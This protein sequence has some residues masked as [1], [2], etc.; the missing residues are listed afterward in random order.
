MK[1][2]WILISVILIITALPYIIWRNHVK[3]SPGIFLTEWYKTI[4][5]T[6]IFG[7][8]FKY[9]FEK[10]ILTAIKANKANILIEALY[11]KLEQIENQLDNN[12]QLT[13]QAT[14]LIKLLIETSQFK[15]ELSFFIKNFG[16]LIS[17]IQKYYVTDEEMRKNEMRRNI[18][19]SLK[20]LKNNLK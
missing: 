8:L 7:L 14:E 20:E 16:D 11:E 1:K 19:F 2:N 9:I 3:F 10:K 12:Q 13:L 15:N 4:L 6:G 18:K 17:K 5:I